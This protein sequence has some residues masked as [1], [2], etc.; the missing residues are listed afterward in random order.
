[1]EWNQIL[2]DSALQNLP[3]KIELNERGNIVMSPASN[4]HGAIQAAVIVALSRFADSGRVVAE[5]SVQTRLGVK[6][7]DVAWGSDGFFR[8]RGHETPYRQ[9]PELCVEIASAS[10][11]KAEM[12]EKIDLYL[13]KGAKEVWICDENGRVSFFSTKGLLARSAIVE[14]FPLE[15]A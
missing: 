12:E 13:A 7:A 1:V 10:N 8:E 6:V 4:K 14:R 5:C 3:Y 15:I 9:S 11:S 2:E